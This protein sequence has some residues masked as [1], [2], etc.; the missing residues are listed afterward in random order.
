MCLSV[1]I[2]ILKDVIMSLFNKCLKDLVF[3]W[4]LLYT[5]I[6]LAD[7]LSLGSTCAY[8][9]LFSKSKLSS[10]NFIFGSAQRFHYLPLKE[11]I[12]TV[13]HSLF[14]ETWYSHSMALPTRLVGV[15]AFLS[16]PNIVSFQLSDDG[17]FQVHH[18]PGW[19]QYEWRQPIC[20]ED[21]RCLV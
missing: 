17:F 13:I 19:S 20:W 11:I 12:A 4:C 18:P 2:A 1:P 21:A 15:S 8:W 3:L 16:L 5:W 10:W 9:M 6:L 14:C 7:S